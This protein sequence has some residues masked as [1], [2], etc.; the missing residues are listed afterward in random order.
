MTRFITSAIDPRKLSMLP[1][2]IARQH[3]GRREHIYGPIQPMEP[4]RRCGLQKIS[5][6]IVIGL[7]AVVVL[8]SVTRGWQW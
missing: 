7:F 2:Q 8:L 4:D 6:A 1:H 5:N 3:P